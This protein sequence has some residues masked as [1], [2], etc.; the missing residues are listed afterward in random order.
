MGKGDNQPVE[1][2]WGWG[3][4]GLLL[5]QKGLKLAQFIP[6]LV[7]VIFIIFKIFFFFLIKKEKSPVPGHSHEQVFALIEIGY[8]SRQALLWKLSGGLGNGDCGL[9]VSHSCH[10]LSQSVQQVSQYV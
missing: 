5:E 3:G 8:H 7:N 2:D 10:V 9:L 6:K 1:G 4:A